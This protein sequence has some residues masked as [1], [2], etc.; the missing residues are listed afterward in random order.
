VPTRPGVWDLFAGGGDFFEPL[1]SYAANEHDFMR[2]IQATL[3]AQWGYHRNDVWFHC[4]HPTTQLVAQGWKIHVSA[5]TSTAFET[6]RRVLPVLVDVGVNFKCAADMRLL[7]A[8]NAK[9]SFRGGSGKFITIYPGDVE[10]FKELLQRLHAVTNDLS[11]PYILSD[12]RYADSKVLFYRYGGILST[13]QRGPDGVARHVIFDPDGNAVPDKRTPQYVQPSWVV[14]PFEEERA[15]PVADEQESRTLNGGRYYIDGVLGYSNSGGVYLATDRHE[16]RR[17]VIK[18]AR[19]LVSRVSETEDAIAILKKEARLLAIAG[20]L[21]VS[22]QLY[23]TFHDWEHFFIV[24]EYVEAITLWTLSAQAMVLLN[25]RPTDEDYAAAYDTFRWVFTQLCD[26]VTA[27]HAKGIVLADLS[28]HNVLVNVQDRRLWL[29]DY[30]AA[31]EPGVDVPTNLSTPGFVSPQREGS[32]T[33]VPTQD[34]DVFALAAI[35]VSY[36]FRITQ[37]LQFERA[38]T[39]RIVRKIFGDARMPAEI[40]RL[41]EAAL[42]NSPAERPAPAVFASALHAA[43]VI[44]PPSPA[45]AADVDLAALT[46]QAAS[47]IHAHATPGSNQRLFPCDFRI[48]NTN[49]VGLFYG[50]A[51]VLSALAYVGEDVPD[52]YVDWTLAH[53]RTTQDLPAGLGLGASGI[54]WALLDLG[55]SDDARAVLRAAEHHPLKN[56]AVELFHG[57]AG[58]GLTEL[59]FFLAFR[60]ER[61]LANARDAGERILSQ[62]RIDDNGNHY[63][64]N[65]G[66]LY[67][68]T[69]GAAGIALFLLYLG[70]A[71]GDETF[72]EHGRR[73]LRHDVSKGVP[74]VYG[75]LEWP[76]S[77]LDSG[78]VSPYW[79]F[80]SAGIG[81]VALRYRHLAGMTEFDDVIE[82]VR[83]S[84]DRVY[85][86]VSNKLFGLSGIGGF[87]LDAYRFTGD[88][89]YLAAARNNLD[90]ILMYAVERPDGLAFPGTEQNKI[91]CDYAVGSAGIMMFL[92][93]LATGAP[94]ELMLDRYFT[95]AART[96]R[97]ELVTA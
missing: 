11:G 34:D 7:S 96:E 68:L 4:V 3:G 81:T 76:Y 15:A 56:D 65:N 86:M 45:L 40:A 38:A 21:G 25:T 30:E 31:F 46:R 17:V 50:S 2:Y 13:M 8:L 52:A 19:P 20:E 42:L 90:G 47:Y 83:L 91:S 39:A 14:D 64:E 57:L 85:T 44:A 95:G 61:H 72:V 22:P 75:G 1:S 43:P 12:R 84:S 94:P 66:V 59:A 53:A 62:A 27:I 26:A 48:Y 55:R 5:T 63:W 87:N 78:I 28:P 9:T 35:M 54:A 16:N 89:R 82:G 77:S 71:T 49:P 6:L 29:I 97:R 92:H 37:F 73:A 33:A 24:Q 70:L 23:D 74:Q 36:V 10:Q 88:E 93:R 67:G 80:G 79:G 69:W 60:D 18:E 41:V 51:G 32:R 58:Y